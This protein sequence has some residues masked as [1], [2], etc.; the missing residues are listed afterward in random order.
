MKSNEK[1]Q[2]F[3]NKFYEFIRDIDRR[4]IFLFIALAVILPIIFQIPFPEIT[5]P[6]VQNVFDQIENTPPGTR[7]LVAFDYDP[8]TEP[9]LQPMANNFVRHLAMRGC[10]MYFIALWPVGQNM[11]E[12]TIANVVEPEFPELVYGEDYCNLGFKS[13][14]EGVIKVVQTDLRKLYPTDANGTDV[15]KVPMLKDVKS[16]RSMGLIVNVSAGYP[17]TKEW[18]QYGS[19]PAGL[20]IVGGCTAV[21]APLFYPYIPNQ[22][23][24]L[25]G[26]I[27]GAAEYDE[28]MKKN[29][30]DETSKRYRAGLKRA[31]EERVEESKSSLEGEDLAK[32][33]QLSEKEYQRKLDSETKDL[34]LGLFRM[35]PQAVAHLVIMFFIVVGNITFFIDRSRQKK[36][37]Q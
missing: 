18:I 12:D 22:L 26:G 21:Q 31:H 7:V 32:A 19:D 3:A 28:A 10:K 34:Y 24:G 11:I 36:S 20:P 5:T 14:N 16:I 4:I 13:G 15:D 33:I 1:K 30:L 35:S 37:G 17:G 25:L 27:K 8:A 9:E 2:S 6:M 23:I 29:Y